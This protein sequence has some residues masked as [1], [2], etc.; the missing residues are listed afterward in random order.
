MVNVSIASAITGYSR[1]IMS[2]FLGDSSIKIWMTDTDSLVTD[3]ILPTGNELGEWKLEKECKEMVFIAPKVYGGIDFNNKEF[4][5]VK[6]YKNKLPYSELKEL[7]DYDKVLQLKHSKSYRKLEESTITLRE[8]LYNLQVT[9]SKRKVIYENGKLV[10]T[11]AYKINFDKV[12]HKTPLK[13]NK[14][15]IKSSCLITGWGSVPK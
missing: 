9:E 15:R 4:T 14:I 1:I 2:K 11:Q 3:T 8:E 12:I 7:L 5:K 10:S 13:L 6:G